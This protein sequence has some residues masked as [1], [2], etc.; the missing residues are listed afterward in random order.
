LPDWYKNF[1]LSRDDNARGEDDEING[2][3]DRPFEAVCHAI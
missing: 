1:I 2:M 3:K